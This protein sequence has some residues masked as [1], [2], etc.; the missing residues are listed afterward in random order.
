MFRKQLVALPIGLS[1]MGLVLSGCSPKLQEFT[2]SLFPGTV[3]SDTRLAS[4]G[5]INDIEALANFDTAAGNSEF[6]HPAAQ[7][8]QSLGREVVTVLAD[9]SLQKEQRIEVF[10]QVIS[11]NL[12]TTLIGRFVIGRHW[13]SLSDDQKSAYLDVFSK[14]IVQNYA[15][16]LGGATEVSGFK[17]I[18]TQP[19]GTNDLL[20]L[21]EIMRDGK[22]VITA[23]WR[24]HER[25]GTYRIVDLKVEGL[26][27]LRT[28]KQE[29]SSFLRGKDVDNLISLLRD[30]TT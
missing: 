2:D 29:F 23:G 9:D 25:D 8:I 18:K 3:A 15:S 14:Y 21:S 11:R 30:R 22:K 16:L 12:D 4:E 28:Q 26:S 10:E 6:A 5:S 27:M 1:L 13:R 7:I 17:I 20:V 19:V 24:M